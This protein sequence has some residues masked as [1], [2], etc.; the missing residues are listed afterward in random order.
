MT[1]CKHA[2]RSRPLALRAT[3]AGSLPAALLEQ[4]PSPEAHATV[5]CGGLADLSRATVTLRGYAIGDAG[6]PASHGRS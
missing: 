1:A 5:D 3:L 6:C 2:R 4:T